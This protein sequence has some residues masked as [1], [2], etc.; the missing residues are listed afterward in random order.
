MTV[1]VCV[2]VHVCVCASFFRWSIRLLECLFSMHSNAVCYI[3]IFLSDVLHYCYS[4]CPFH[5]HCKQLKFCLS[6]DYWMLADGCFCTSY[7]YQC[8][9]SNKMLVL[10]GV[11]IEL[12]TWFK[13][14]KYFRLLVKSV[15]LHSTRDSDFLCFVLNYIWYLSS[16]WFDISALVTSQSIP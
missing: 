12:L 10:R 16:Q 3:I 5:Y 4:L 6:I 7:F 11:Q 2:H 15:P 1:C 9:N 8:S 13:Q 14:Y